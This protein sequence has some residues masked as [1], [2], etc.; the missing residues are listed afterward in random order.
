MLFIFSLLHLQVTIYIKSIIF[1]Y[2]TIVI[3]LLL[4]LRRFFFLYIHNTLSLYVLLVVFG[5]IYVLLPH[6]HECGHTC[7]NLIGKLSINVS[8]HSLSEFSAK[9]HE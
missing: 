1:H 9:G 7:D 5:V 3:R 8:T 2:K 4:I 6:L